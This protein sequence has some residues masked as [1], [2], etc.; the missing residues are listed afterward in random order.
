MEIP[1]KMKRI[2]LKE[3]NAD[4]EK[5]KFEVQECDVPVPKSGEVLVRMVAAPVN[6]SDYGEW[7]R[8]QLDPEKPFYLGKEGSGV[9]VASG[10]GMKA[11]GLVGSKVGICG[12]KDGGSYQEYVC[13]DAMKS[14]FPLPDD[15]PVEDA[16]SFFVNPYTAVGI[17]ATAREAGSPGFVHTAAA[18]QLGQMLVKLCKQEAMTLINVVR[19]SEQADT[20]KALGAE[21]IIDSSKETWKEDLKKLIKELNIT[22]AFDAI[23]GDNTGA[24]LDAL[25]NGSTCFVYGGLS[26]KPVGGISPMDLIYRKKKVEGFL[27]TSYLFGASGGIV[28]M[29]MRVN[30]MSK[31][32]N[33]GLANGWSASQFVDVTP[34]NWWSKFLE[35]RTGAGFTNQKLRIRFPQ[36]EPK[37]VEAAAAPET[38]AAPAAAETE[39][40][41]AE[42]AEAPAAA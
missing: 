9:V 12:M 26:E 20:L 4:I 14:A 36:P 25:P 27:L 34:E 5:A 41:A 3:A 17:V 39:A 21:H 31:T 40:K 24:M 6:P 15:V 23:A 32:V 10:G 30:N 42:P 16:A 28:G 38:E 19:R 7:R 33:P 18:S 29:G 37:V 13:V 11:N 35:L 2:V 8:A 1:T 22:C